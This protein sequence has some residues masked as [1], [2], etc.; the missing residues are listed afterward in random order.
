MKYKKTIC[1]RYQRIKMTEKI[2]GLVGNNGKGGRWQYLVG[3]GGN[4]GWVNHI[5]MQSLHYITFLNL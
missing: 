3:G 2:L 1:E 4:R 5:L